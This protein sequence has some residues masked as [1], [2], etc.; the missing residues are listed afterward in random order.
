M[1][2]FHGKPE[3]KE[4]YLNRI[5]LHR[6]ADQIIHGSYWENGKGCAVGCTI[7]GSQH[8]RYEIELGI[9][10]NLAYLEDSIFEGL[11]N[12]AALDFPEQFLSA[13][14]VGADL[15]MV[16]YK[17]MVWMLIDPLQGVLRFADESGSI[18]IKR[19]AELHQ[20]EINRAAAGAAAWAAA[21]DAAGAAAR[22][23]AWAAARIQQR[24]Q[25]LKLLSEV[26]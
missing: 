6:A 18:A 19:V 3:I 25:L 21:G 5:R 8:D 14:K 26:I 16:Y 9:P 4:E 7:H 10:K 23:A 15:S 13:I 11:S 2:A 24:D 22:A 17:F 12:G 20:L 1:K